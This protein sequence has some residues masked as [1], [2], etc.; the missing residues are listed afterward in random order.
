MLVGSAGGCGDG[1]SGL[2]DVTAEVELDGDGCSESMALGVEGPPVNDVRVPSSQDGEVVWSYKD[3]GGLEI[4]AAAASTSEVFIAAGDAVSALRQSDGTTRWKQALDVGD[5]SPVREQFGDDGLWTWIHRLAVDDVLAVAITENSTDLRD[6]SS[7]I[8]VR[9]VVSALDPATGAQRWVSEALEGGP[10]IL[11]VVDDLIVVEAA[12]G[13]ESTVWAFEAATGRSRWRAG[14]QLVGAGDNTVFIHRHD[15]CLV[16]A[17]DAVNG[18]ARW[19][20]PTPPQGG[21]IPPAP[22]VKVLLD[23]D[24]AVIVWT[25]VGSPIVV[26]RVDARTG[27]DLWRFHLPAG[28]WW[29]ADVATTDASLRVAIARDDKPALDVFDLAPTSGEARWAVRIPL[30]VVGGPGDLDEINRANPFTQASVLTIAPSNSTMS[31]G[32]ETYELSPSD[33]RVERLVDVEEP[34]AALMVGPVDGALLMRTVPLADGV[35]ATGGD[36]AVL[37]R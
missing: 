14:G 26:A 15:R 11:A 33:G 19:A 32:P 6:E 16:H 25:Q 37:V 22:P 12:E 29:E 36:T 23:G 9:T 4:R 21:L 3:T 27:A 34:L 17:I 13:L 1:E 35:I 7:D 18:V 5:L 28:D 8:D 30:P 24:N 20:L 2:A 31:T 10:A